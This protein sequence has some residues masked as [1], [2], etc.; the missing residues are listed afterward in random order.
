MEVRPLPSASPDLELE[1]LEASFE[2]LAFAAFPPMCCI[3]RGELFQVIA[4]YAGQSRI[5][6]DSDFADFLNQPVVEGE[7]DIHFH[8]IRETRNPCN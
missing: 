1:L 2:R 4:N 6:L 7:R 3:F 8:I 5:P